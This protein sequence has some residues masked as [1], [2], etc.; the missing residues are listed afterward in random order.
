MVQLISSPCGRVTQLGETPSTNPL[1]TS[2]I[3]DR[4]P[5]AEGVSLGAGGAADTGPSF[6]SAAGSGSGG[7]P[8]GTSDEDA[9]QARL[10][11]LKRS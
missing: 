5:V 1:S 10:D 7:G 9:L 3:A 6:G 2:T 11:S 8:R 4:Q